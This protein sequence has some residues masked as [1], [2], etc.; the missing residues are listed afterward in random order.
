[1]GGRLDAHQD[2]V[3]CRLGIEI[4]AHGVF[5]EASRAVQGSG[6]DV[7]LPNLKL[8]N[9]AFQSLCQSEDAIEQNGAKPLSMTFR[10]DGEGAELQLID[11]VPGSEVAQQGRIGPGGIGQG[12]VGLGGIRQDIEDADRRVADFANE[13]SSAPAGFT[14]GAL[15]QRGHFI[16]ICERHWA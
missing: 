2:P 13:V 4:A 10:I 14:E 11:D 1:M 7:G 12:G 6:R 9:L 15:I 16:D 8:N 3:L 5:L